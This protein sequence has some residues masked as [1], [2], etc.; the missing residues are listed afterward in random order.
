MLVGTYIPQ[1][2]VYPGFGDYDMPYRPISGDSSPTTRLTDA[3]RDTAVARLT[4]HVASGRLAIDDFDA[5]AGLVYAAVTQADL[6]AVFRDLP[7][8]RPAYE[9]PEPKRLPMSREL[10]TW[11]SVG[12]L[13]LSIWAITSVA[14]GSFLYPWPVWVIGPWGAMLAFQR[15][16]GV[17]VGCP[18]S[19]VYGG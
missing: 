12:V 15:V 5:R 19:R 3:Q 9:K 4:S 17:S 8:P 16:T 10:L 7:S 1:W 11:A 2:N 18:S 14:T 6:D 13:C